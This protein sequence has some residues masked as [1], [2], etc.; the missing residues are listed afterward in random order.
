MDTPTQAHIPSL[1]SSFTDSAFFSKFRSKLEQDAK[2][3]SVRAIFHLCGNGVLEDDRYKEFMDGFGCDVHVS[4]PF[5]ASPRML[6]YVS[7][8][9]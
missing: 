4:A 5:T 7:S 3:Y 6:T 9:S 2:Q 8:T 1:S